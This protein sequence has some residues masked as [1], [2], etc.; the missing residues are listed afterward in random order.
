MT[1]AERA[2]VREQI[3][4]ERRRRI[5]MSRATECC[6]CGESLPADQDEGRRRFCV[7]LHRRLWNDKY[8]T[9]LPERSKR[10]ELV[11][12]YQDEERRLAAR[13]ESWR[14]STLKRYRQYAELT[15]RLGVARQRKWAAHMTEL[16]QQ[17]AA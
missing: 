5:R 17:V 1:A 15:D 9:W 7:D 3:D 16:R 2:Y 12:G 8:G 13:R 4:A 10:T 14:Q 11:F 6:W